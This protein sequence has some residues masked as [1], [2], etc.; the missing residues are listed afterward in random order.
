MILT[1]KLKI[2]ID[3]TLPTEELTDNYLT[4]IPNAMA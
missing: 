4:H 1:S 3:A 2:E